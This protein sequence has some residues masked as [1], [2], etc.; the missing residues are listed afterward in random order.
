MRGETNSHESRTPPRCKPETEAT[1]K[2]SPVALRP[3]TTTIQSAWKSWISAGRHI[4][5]VDDDDWDPSEVV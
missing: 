3:A 4:G 1:P 2:R 5:I